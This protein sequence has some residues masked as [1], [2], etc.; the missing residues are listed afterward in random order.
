[1]YEKTVGTKEEYDVQY[2][3]H[4]GGAP[5]QPHDQVKRLPILIS[6]IIG[7]SRY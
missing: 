6:Q 2:S 3:D 7:A 1:M 4:A 5:P